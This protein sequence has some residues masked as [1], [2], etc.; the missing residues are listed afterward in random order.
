MLLDWLASRP[1]ARL[2]RRGDPR[3]GMIG[4]SYGGGIQL[5]VA[6]MDCRLD[7]IVP[8][9]AWHSLATGLFPHGSPKV[10]RI[11]GL[12]TGAERSGG[13]VD[14]R[15]AQAAAQ[16]SAEGTV[17]GRIVEWFGRRGPGDRVAKITAPTL[18]VQGTID[19]LFPPSEA[20]ANFEAL[21]SAGTPVA[22][23]WVCQGH[24]VCLTAPGDAAVVQ[25][26]TFAWLDHHLRGDAVDPGPVVDVIDQD[27]RRWTGDR[28]AAPARWITAVGEGGRLAL[29]E[30]S[31]AGPIVPVPGGAPDPMTPGPAERAIE[32]EIRS[33]G[34]HIVVGAPSLTFT[35]RGTT[36]KGSRPTRSS[37]SSS[38]TRP[39]WCS[40]TRSHP[41][42]SPSTASATPRGSTWR[43]SPSTSAPERP[44]PSRS[45]P[46]HPCSPL[47]ASGGPSTSGAPP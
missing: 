1:E 3:V 30:T 22:M 26:R 36:S 42:P 39:A 2:D 10:G 18:I 40:A 24:G 12:T 47:P 43:R 15:V 16:A 21:R 31:H 44:S 19:T 28:Y 17:D 25:V 7:A 38:T 27:G 41:Y 11:E 29:D 5:V 46:P 4:G 9:S 23:M 20:V 33:R 8:T 35:Y 14:R 6:A 32:L 34:D 37:P 13:R 45:W